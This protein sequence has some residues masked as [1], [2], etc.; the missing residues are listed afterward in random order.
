MNATSCLANETNCD[1]TTASLQQCGQHDNEFPAVID[2]LQGIITLF[3]IAGSLCI[4]LVI[5]YM[6]IRSKKLHQKAFYL[7]LQLMVVNVLFALLVLPGVVVSSIA[8][9]W[10]FGKVICVILGMLNSAF[11]IAQ[12]FIALVLT[13]DRFF[14]IFAPFFY[15]QHGTKVAIVMSLLL[16]LFA[17][18][19]AI[20]VYVLGC[21][22]Y[23]PSFKLCGSVGGCMPVCAATN[24]VTAGIVLLFCAILP[25]LLYVM[26]V[27]E[28]QTA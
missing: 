25:I 16:W 8:R 15:E 27:C 6:I 26:T 28:R 20:I 13:L 11:F 12:Y 21:I 23:V 10:I 22:A 14:T 2:Y 3:I 17:L 18:C 5:I 19:R 4:N 24:I 9:E 1:N 7:A